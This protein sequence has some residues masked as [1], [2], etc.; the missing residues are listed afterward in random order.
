[1]PKPSKKTLEQKSGG[2]PDVATFRQKRQDLNQT[3]D[4]LSRLLA[5]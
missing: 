5:R 3:D 4:H 2:T 1:M